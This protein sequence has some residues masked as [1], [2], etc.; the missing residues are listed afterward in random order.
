MTH[1]KLT[2]FCELEIKPLQ[3]LLQPDVVAA[4]VDMKASLSLG[5]L[6]LSPERAKVVQRLT[7]AGV[8]VNAWLLLPKEQ[9]YWFNLRNASQA[10]ERYR[11]FRDWT[12]EYDLRWAGIGLDIEPDINDLRTLFTTR[13]RVMPEVF[14]RTFQYRQLKVARQTYSE[15][16]NRIRADGYR[17][18]SYQFPFIAE[19]RLAGSTLLQRVAGLVDLK[20]DREVWMLYTSFFRPNGAG[21]LASYAPQAQAIG[22]GVTGGGVDPGFAPPPDL[23]WE[24]LARDLRLAWYW[25]DDLHIFS[26]EGCVQRGFLPRLKS[27]AWDFPILLPESSQARV[28]AWRDSVRSALWV[29][30]HLTAIL[31]MIGGGILLGVSLGRYLRKRRAWH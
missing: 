12:V 23:S 19:E 18:D 4:L 5:I 1:P 21:L 28:D 26:L 9:G 13:W 30:A 20:V 14:R 29:N 17:V 11:Q 10:A 16:V 3:D 15:L 24:E 7:Q 31:A 27:F 25:C 8:A 6:D 22:L 2:F